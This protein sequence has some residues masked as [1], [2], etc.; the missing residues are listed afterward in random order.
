MPRALRYTLIIGSV[1]TLLVIALHQTGWLTP[2]DRQLATI[3]GLGLATPIHHPFI[4]IAA[5]VLL[6][7]GVAWTTI[8]INRFDLKALVAG[9]ALVQLY[10]GAALLSLF[11]VY[12]SPLLPGLAVVLAFVAAF[13]YARTEEGQRQ[14]HVEVLYGRR[15]S[16]QTATT[17]V[18]GRAPIDNE[19]QMRE[20][21]I[22]VC[23]IFNHPSLMA[24]LAPATYIALNNEFLALASESLVE[25]GGCLTECDGEGVRVIFGTPLPT[26]DHAAEACRAALTLARRLD[27]FNQ[28]VA[29]EHGQVCDWRIGVNSGLMIIGSFGGDRLAGFG[30]AGEEVEFARR[31][32]AANLIYGSSVL[33]GARTYEMAEGA[34]EVRPMELLRRRQDESWLE[35]YELLGLPG[36][37]S[38]ADRERSDLYWTGVILYREKRLG[39]ALEKFLQVRAMTPGHDGPVDFYLQRIRSLQLSNVG[40]EFETARL[41]HSI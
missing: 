33:A 11:G 22:V 30:V 6:A 7:F 3:F 15:I 12:F 21:T 40:A 36:E 27:A 20:L 16:D 37:M 4:Q 31:L 34:V 14:R 35:V 25:S 17:L 18:N 32:C 19:G 5:I 13:V 38:A 28:R 41:L 9:S 8:D 1:V 26:G 2:L 24:E 23:E 29:A 39:E 10:T